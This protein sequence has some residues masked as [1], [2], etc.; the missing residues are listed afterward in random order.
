MPNNWICTGNKKYE[1]VYIGDLTLSSRLASLL[2]RWKTADIVF[3][4]LSFCFQ[5]WRYSPTAA[6]SLA[7]LPLPASLHQ[8]A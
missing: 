7:T 6:K 2:L 4:V 8:H 1:K 5:V 3:V